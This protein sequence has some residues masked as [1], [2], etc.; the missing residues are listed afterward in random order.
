MCYNSN[1]L[2]QNKGVGNSSL[3][4]T[5]ASL[6]GTKYAMVENESL[7]VTKRVASWT[8]LTVFVM[9][10]FFEGSLDQTHM[11]YI[12]R[13]Y[14]RLCRSIT[15]LDLITS[16]AC[17]IGQS[18]IIWS[19]DWY[20]FVLLAY[21]IVVYLDSLYILN[22]NVSP[23]PWSSSNCEERTLYVHHQFS[24]FHSRVLFM[25]QLITVLW[26]MPCSVA[27]RTNDPA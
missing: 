4:Y 2:L 11:E 16:D 27:S 9:F 21:L 25:D 6:N 26:S 19:D 20:L 1:E 8:A 3:W 10:L 5:D 24:R 7:T 12:Y 15:S 22:L 23:L 14:I 13:Q 18:N 17:C